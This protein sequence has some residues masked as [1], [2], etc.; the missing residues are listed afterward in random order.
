[1]RLRGFQKRTA[2]ERGDGRAGLAL[3]LALTLAVAGR[4][5]AEPEV[6]Q[7]SAATPALPAQPVHERN[8]DL[9]GKGGLWG[10]G[11]DWR[12]T[13]RLAV[14]AVGSLYLLGAP[15]SHRAPRGRA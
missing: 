10:I 14:G 4:V 5:S 1:M 11:Y 8:V 13:A 3:T 15:P 7:S 2:L 6:S 9:L 12:P